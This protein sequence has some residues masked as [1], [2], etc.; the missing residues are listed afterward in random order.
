MQGDVKHHE[1]QLEE[2]FYRVIAGQ[3]GGNGAFHFHG[4]HMVFV[5]LLQ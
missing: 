3:G 5:V 1:I 4:R 2:L